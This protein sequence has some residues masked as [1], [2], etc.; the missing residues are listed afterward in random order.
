MSK[1]PHLREAA[2]TD[3][4][5][6]ADAVR[7][8]GELGWQQVLELREVSPL[9][10]DASNLAHRRRLWQPGDLGEHVLPRLAR[11]RPIVRLWLLI[12]VAV[13]QILHQLL[14]V[15]VQHV[16]YLVVALFVA[17]VDT[18]LLVGV[19]LDPDVAAVLKQQPRGLEVAVPARGVQCGMA[20]IALCVDRDLPALQ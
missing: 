6:I 17:P 5:D 2:R 16:E 12:A 18:G 19:G 10:G 9:P 20:I 14:G 4:I 8:H 3:L 13:H 1:L 15:A 7:A 11:L